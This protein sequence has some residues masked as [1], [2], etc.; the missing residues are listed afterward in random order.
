L[1]S[2]PG[3]G[4]R[5]ASLSER[6]DPRFGPTHPSVRWALGFPAVKAAGREP[7]EPSS[8]SAEVKH[9]WSNAP[10]SPYAVMARYLI[11]HRHNFAFSFRP[12]SGDA[13][14]VGDRTLRS[15]NTENVWKAGA[16][17]SVD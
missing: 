13:A 3:R 12:N 14:G 16:T 5:R 17:V 4:R 15:C 6:P 11:K 7:Y 1:G 9:E 8:S 10:T 2:V